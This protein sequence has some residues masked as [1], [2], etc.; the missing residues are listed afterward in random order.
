MGKSV[1]GAYLS[2]PIVPTSTWCGSPSCFLFNL[3][4]GAKLPYHARNAADV[5]SEDPLGFYMQEDK[6]F[7]GYGD[8]SI[9]EDLLTGNSEIENC[10]GMGLSAGSP[11]ALCMMAGAPSFDIE[12]LEIWALKL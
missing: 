3:S 10:Y 6:M 2:H 9:N 1:F 5:A 11:E 4:V 7:F 12:D 8:L